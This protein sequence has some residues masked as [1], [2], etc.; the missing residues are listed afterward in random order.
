MQ[1]S[2]LVTVSLASIF[3]RVICPMWMAEVLEGLP[4]AVDAG[5]EPPRKKT[6]TK[7]E[8]GDNQQLRR[9]VL[10]S[11]APELFIENE[12]RSSGRATSH[13]EAYSWL[14]TATTKRDVEAKRQQWQEAGCAEHFE[15][16]HTGSNKPFLIK[17]CVPASMHAA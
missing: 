10:P 5:E 17:R 15:L 6:K 3:P 1:D 8:K 4:A 13:S 11:L 12:G 9:T 14:K 2:A 7:A 16:F